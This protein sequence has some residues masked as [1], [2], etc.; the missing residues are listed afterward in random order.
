[1]TVFGT[2][3]IQSKVVDKTEGQRCKG[4]AFSIMQFGSM[5]QGAKSREWGFW[6]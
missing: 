1:M 2:R 4:L 3:N 6:V 5:V